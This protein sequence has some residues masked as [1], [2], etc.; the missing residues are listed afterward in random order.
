LVMNGWYIFAN[1]LYLNF[2]AQIKKITQR[3]WEKLE[4]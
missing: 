1:D 2:L 3:G 4:N